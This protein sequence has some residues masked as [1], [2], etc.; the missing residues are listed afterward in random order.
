M[1]YAKYI[2]SLL[3]YMV[4]I[5]IISFVAENYLSGGQNTDITNCCYLL[6]I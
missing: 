2:W 4:N 6:R 3:T 1:L 5:I